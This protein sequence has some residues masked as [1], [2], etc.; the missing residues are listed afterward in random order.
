MP[1]ALRRYAEN[2]K[3][4]ADASRAEIERMLVRHQIDRFGYSQ[5][6]TGAS[7]LFTYDDQDYRIDL[8]YPDLYSDEIQ[9]RPGGTRRTGQEARAY[10]EQRIREIWRLLVLLVKTKLYADEQGM[11]P[12]QTGFLPYALIGNGR[13]V[14][15]SIY[16]DSRGDL[17]LSDRQPAIQL[18]APKE[19]P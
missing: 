4:Q 2:T 1:K 14:Q 13:T 17:Q 5:T 9:L 10:R 8:P 18:P 6:L 15:Q 19:R 7:I 11:E 16:R 3:T 12:L